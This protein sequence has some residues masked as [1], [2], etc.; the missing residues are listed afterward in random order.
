[1]LS[2]AECRELVSA[3]RGHA[4]EAGVTPQKAAVLRNIAHS[5]AGLAHQFEMLATCPD[6][7]GRPHQQN[8]L[9]GGLF[10]QQRS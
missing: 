8:I 9:A 10:L 3:Y 6:E 5:Y 7:D 2:A 4:S 1:M